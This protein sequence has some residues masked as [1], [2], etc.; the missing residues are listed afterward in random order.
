M[1][2]SK[3]SGRNRLSGRVRSSLL[4]HIRRKAMCTLPD[5]RVSAFFLGTRLKRALSNLTA[6]RPE[7]H[8]QT[9]GAKMFHNLVESNADRSEFKRRTSFFLAT[10]VAYSLAL[11]VAAIVGIYTYDARVDAQTNE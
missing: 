2:V 7:R 1:K 6:S 3:R 4:G 11:F 10:V 5:G 8:R 9:G